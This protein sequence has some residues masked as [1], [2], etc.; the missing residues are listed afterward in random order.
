MA[1]LYNDELYAVLDRLLPG[2]QFVRRQRPTDPW[3]DKVCR[4]AKRATRR[5]ERWI[6]CCQLP[7]C[8]RRRLL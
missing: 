3:F 1:A 6:R 2:S 8:S 7:S 5:I 4:D